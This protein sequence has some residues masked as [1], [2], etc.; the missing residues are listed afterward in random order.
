MDDVAAFAYE[1]RGKKGLSKLIQGQ[2]AVSK[3]LAVSW[4]FVQMWKKR[5]EKNF[6]FTA[7]RTDSQFYI[8]CAEST[9]DTVINHLRPITAWLSRSK[10]VKEHVGA[11]V[12]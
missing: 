8:M 7:F 6:C 4:D 10:R 5:T 1:F 3:I 12:E 9:T 11:S 2:P